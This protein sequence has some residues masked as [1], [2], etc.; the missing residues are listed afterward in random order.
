M[1][2]IPNITLILMQLL[3]FFVTLFGLY[4]IIFKPMLEYLD[5][6]NEQIEGSQKKALTLVEEANIQAKEAEKKL[7]AAKKKANQ[8]R[9]KGTDKAMKEYTEQVSQARRE[10]YASIQEAEVE[11][12]KSCEEARSNLKLTANS[13]ASEISS[14]I[15]GRHV[16]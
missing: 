7:I 9:Q 13:I 6:R 16:T 4:F 10:A 8:V 14:S 3:P 5:K 15:L 2:L 11:I 12:A 1:Y